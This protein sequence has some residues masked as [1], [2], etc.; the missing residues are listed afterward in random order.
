L[1][2]KI[3]GDVGI[4]DREI[5]DIYKSAFESLF[6]EEGM[7]SEDSYADTA[8]TAKYGDFTRSIQDAFQKM[9]WLK[10]NVRLSTL[11]EKALSDEVLEKIDIICK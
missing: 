1:T 9:S 4:F 10:E 2:D 6:G 3:K 7:I 5:Y 8:S 11:R